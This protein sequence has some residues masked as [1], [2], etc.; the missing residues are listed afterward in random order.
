MMFY[1]II[2][3]NQVI[4]VNNQTFKAQKYPHIL[5]PSNDFYCEYIMSSDGSQLYFTNWT[6]ESKYPISS[7]V[8]TDAIIIDEA[9]Y[10]QLL[11]QLKINEKIQYVEKEQLEEIEVITPIEQEQQV[12]VLD[13]IAMKKK[14]LEL[15]E[16]VQ[17]LL[18]K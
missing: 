10:L 3:N 5:V 11:D 9:E 2:Q 15:E 14:I 17:K 7:A 13:T 12:E 16:L 1:K 18:N 4:D 6:A 8:Y